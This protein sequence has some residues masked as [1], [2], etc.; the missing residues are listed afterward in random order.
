MFHFLKFLFLFFFIFHLTSFFIF[1]IFPFFFSDDFLLWKFDFLGLQRTSGWAR[2][3]H[4]RVT[5]MFFFF[6]VLFQTHFAAGIG[7]TATRTSLPALAIFCPRGAAWLAMAML[8]RAHLKYARRRRS[9]R[10]LAAPACSAIEA[11]RVKSIITK[12]HCANQGNTWRCR[13]CCDC[14]C[15]CRRRRFLFCF[16]FCF[17]CD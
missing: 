8:I 3:A 6:L 7:I 15:R 10:L 17:C 2:K 1:P 11:V 9:L 4:L 12:G 14:D 13:C 5:P 16:C